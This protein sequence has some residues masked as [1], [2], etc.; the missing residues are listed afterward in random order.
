[1]HILE[2]LQTKNKNSEFN[3]DAE[4]IWYLQNVCYEKR[5]SDLIFLVLQ[6]MGYH[7]TLNVC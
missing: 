7:A 6:L 5:G 1:M 2:W 4:K 3:F